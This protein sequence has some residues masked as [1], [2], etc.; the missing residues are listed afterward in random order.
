LKIGANPYLFSEN[1]CY[2]HR[3]DSGHFYNDLKTF[4]HFD[5]IFTA[6]NYTAIPD[7]WI[8]L[9]SDI[10]GSSEAIERGRYKDVNVVGAL[11]IIAILNCVKDVDIPYVFGGDGATILIPPQYAQEAQAALLET[12]K[13]A[14]D[15]FSLLL[16]IGMFTGSEIRS[17]GHQ[18]DILKFEVSPYY[19]QAMIFG[20]GISYAEKIIKTPQGSRFH[21][22][23]NGQQPKG[24]FTGLECRWQDIKSSLDETCSFMVMALGNR[25]EQQNTYREVHKT[26]E[27]LF[28]SKDHRRA[29][30]PT[31]LSLSYRPKNLGIET[32]IFCAGKNVF[33][34]IVYFFKL[35][36]TNCLGDL[37]MLFKMKTDGDDWGNYKRL[38][39]DTVD[40]EKFD[41][42]LRMV[43][44]CTTPARKK[45]EQYLEGQYQDKKLIY[46][47]HVSDRALMTCLIFARHGKQV[48]FVD[49]ADGGYAKASIAFKD[50]LY[51]ALRDG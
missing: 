3:M 9:I 15:S 44:S 26:I 42:L 30:K 36:F 24:D 45:F 1:F 18:L 22:Q 25:D 14:M 17:A 37:L 51:Y 31:E 46:G 19:T 33:Q 13:V 16:R 27:Q 28:G 34:R 32:N 12:Q 10:Q 47:V 23:Q 2:N 7:D 20:E 4:S 39:S 5:D 40:N 11:S 21:I 48:H 50:R 6:S 43:L 38:V 35:L 49:A 8:V 41:N 29:A